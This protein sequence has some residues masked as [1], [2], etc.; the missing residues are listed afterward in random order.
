MPT[1]KGNPHN[2]LS[3]VCGWSLYRCTKCGTVGCKHEGCSNYI[4]IHLAVK[5]RVC[6]SITF[7]AVK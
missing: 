5:C 1:C 3:N 4:G 2:Q 6:G 7:E